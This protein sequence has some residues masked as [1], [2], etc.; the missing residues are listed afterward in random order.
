M[1]RPAR[2]TVVADVP[3]HDHGDPAPASRSGL[4]AMGLAGGLVPSP[5]ALLVFL[6]ALAIGHAWFGVLLVVAFGLGMAMT[7]CTLGLL[8]MQFR[9][10]AEQRLAHRSGTRFPA[11]LRAL[12]VATACGV[13]VLGLAIA[14]QAAGG[15]G[16]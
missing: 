7:L 13:L 2:T 10:T 16:R 3:A 11:I 15:I 4:V 12:P 14:A 8:I 6:A 1:V 5:S 9:A